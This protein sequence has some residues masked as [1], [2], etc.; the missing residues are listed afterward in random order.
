MTSAFPSLAQQ[1]GRPARIGFLKYLP[2]DD[3][4]ELASFRQ[5]M[6]ELGH[7]EGKTY[8]LEIRVADSKVE[9]LPA[10]AEELVRLKPD[11]IWVTTTAGV[12]A[13]VNA[14]KTIPVVCGS[15]SN[16]VRDGLVQSLARP[17]G[18]LTGPSLMTGDLAGKQL[19]MLREILPKLSRLATFIVPENHVIFLGE[20][21]LAAKLLGVRVSLYEAVTLQDVEKAI[22]TARS[23]GAQAVLVGTAALFRTNRKAIADLALKARLPTLFPYLEAVQDGGLICYGPSI[24]DV[25]RRSAQYVD[26]ILKGAKPGDLPV[27]QPTT[28]DLAINKK[29]AAA[30]GV[31]FPYSILIR[32]TNVIE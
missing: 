16:P 28:F 22:S 13:V 15:F 21:E 31:K 9:R 17:G 5:G 19:E 14:T 10:L 4:A 25:F 11:V 3:E 8:T 7:V 20:L 26:K 12:R 24:T 6:R 18:N 2:R 1:P 23:T 29:T 32:A 27:E 30:L